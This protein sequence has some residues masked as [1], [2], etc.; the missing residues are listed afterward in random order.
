VRARRSRRLLG[1][2]T[3]QLID[4]RAAAGFEVSD[5]RGHFAELVLH[6]GELLLHLLRSCAS[7]SPARA[8]SASSRA[9][10]V[11]MRLP[12]AASAAVRAAGDAVGDFVGIGADG[13]LHPAALHDDRRGTGGGADEMTMSKVTTKMLIMKKASHEGGDTRFPSTLT[14]FSCANPP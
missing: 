14:D 9:R 12:S 5:Q 2:R 7:V 6:G 13:S 10:L 3:E 8:R 11:S 4:F 1:Q